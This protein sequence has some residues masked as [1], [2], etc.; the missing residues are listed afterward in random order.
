[1]DARFWEAVEREDVGSLMAALGVDP[2]ER[3]RTADAMEAAV[4]VLSSWRRRRDEK[5]AV[6]R[7]RYR[8]GWKPLA[9]PAPGLP[10][11]TW[12]VVVPQGTDRAGELLDAL[13][14]QGMRTVV[15]PYD[16][17]DRAELTELLRKQVDDDLGGV[18]SLLAL[19]DRSSGASAALSAG[20]EATL[21][22]VQAL[23]DAGVTAPLW[24]VTSGAVGTGPAD[25][26]R[27]PWQALVWGLGRAVP[28][29]SPDRWGGLVDLP[30]VIDER[31]V[32]RLLGALSGQ[33]GEDQLAV[34]PAGVLAR[35]LGRDTSRA[36]SDWRVR[37]TVLVTSGTEGLGRHAARWLAGAGAEHLVLTAA[38]GTGGLPEELGG[39][40]CACTVIET[41]L[42]TRD[43]VA[44]L[45]ARVDA[46]GLT[47]D[48][49]VHAAD[50]VRTNPVVGTDTTELVEVL[51]A[52][53]D[54][55]VHLD[56]LLGDRPLDMFVV[57]SS[58]AGVWGGGGQG[59]SGAAN[60][61]LDALVE[62]RR[63]RGLPSLS[64]AWGVVEGIGVGADEATVEQLRRRGVSPVAAGLV[65]TALS[66]TVTQDAPAS[67]TVADIDWDR[68]VPAFTGMRGSPLLTDLPEARRIIEA[69]ATDDDGD[70][71]GS[72][73]L[74]TLLDAPEAEQERILMKLVRSTAATVLG[75]SGQDAISPHSPFQEMGFDSLAAVGLRNSLGAAVSTRLPATLT[76]DYPTPAALV[77]YLRE[78][79]VRAY[80]QGPSQEDTALAE[81]EAEI[82][83]ALAAVPLNALRDAGILDALL[84]LAGDGTTEDE[85]AERDD[86]DEELI[87]AMDVDDLLQRALGSTQ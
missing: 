77:G 27:S 38:P 3:E 43:G 15:L 64:V 14:A 16:G 56:E 48:A 57:F 23:G 63:A 86:S 28:L 62:R 75:H 37:G 52:K 13:A 36:V 67:V 31:A 17:A 40:G 2:E 79:L 39:L 68:F 65:V 50:L 47:L 74:R 51:A 83:R 29:E 19:D 85:P 42:T 34:R 46:L 12:L 9:N 33:D 20:A 6:D 84:D 73:F 44:D 87:D 81:R 59:T 32:R 61:F 70:D 72:E 24:C 11:G 66:Q 18:L 60:A 7:L 8:V 22:L 25:P 69:A 78:H 30:D 58:I 82:R 54:G 41:D 21:T 10:A 53:A 55:V 5:S 71:A 4:G 35:R 49:V 76:F 80:A 45:L 26:V 1:M